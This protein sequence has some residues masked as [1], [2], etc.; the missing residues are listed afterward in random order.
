MGIDFCRSTNSPFSR[1]P[2]PSQTASTDPSSP[3]PS[4]SLLHDNPPL[5][6]TPYSP[7][8]LHAFNLGVLYAL[9]A[10]LFP[11]PNW[12]RAKNAKLAKA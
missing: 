9:C 5:Q 4:P 7:T 12:L 10:N 6:H 2:S 3:S 8:T 1:N 11:R